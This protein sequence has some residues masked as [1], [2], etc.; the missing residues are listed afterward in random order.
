VIAFAA[1]F[2]L[3]KLGEYRS[4]IVP[5]LIVAAV[6]AVAMFVGLGIL[7]VSSLRRR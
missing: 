6:G 1:M 3:S 5:Y 7:V 4:I 2:A